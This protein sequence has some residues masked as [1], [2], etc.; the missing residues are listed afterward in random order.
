VFGQL[1]GL[2]RSG[3]PRERATAVAI[4]VSTVGAVSLVVTSFAAVAG[5]YRDGI[6]DVAMVAL[7]AVAV[8]WM[9]FVL[10]GDLVLAKVFGVD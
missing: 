3:T 6:G 2:V 5:Y 10:L 9:G 1:L 4:L 7:V 8:A